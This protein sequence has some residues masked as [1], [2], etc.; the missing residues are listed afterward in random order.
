MLAF[1]CLG[2]FG[3]LQ[4]V[5]GTNPNIG[6]AELIGSA[7]FLMNAIGLAAFKSVPV[8]RNTFMFTVLLFLMVM[9]AS[10]GTHNTGILWFFV[11]PVAAFLLSDIRGGVFWMAALVASSVTVWLLAMNG[12]VTIAYDT[13]TLRQLMVSVLVVGSGIYVYQWSLEQS[14][15]ETK[16]SREELHGERAEADKVKSEF[17]TLASHQLRTPISAIAW[18]SELLL[19]GDAGKLN[20]EQQT[21]VEGIYKSNRRMAN[22]VNE[23]LIVSSLEQS[24]LP[25]ILEKT[26][27]TD[28]ASAAI[29]EQLVERHEPESRIKK[30][31]TT[32]P[33]IMCDPNVAKII[34]HHLIHN[35][36]KYTPQNGTITVRIFTDKQ[37]VGGGNVIF[38]VADTGY[39]IPKSAVKKIF[40]K[41][42]RA[43]NIL[44]KDT[45]GTGL[46]LYIVKELLNYVGGTISFRS[47]EGEG[48]TFTVQIPLQGMKEHTPKTR[49]VGPATSRSVMK[50]HAHV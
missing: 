18:T 35:A 40:T 36:L 6:Y 8:A 46:G 12:I 5:N 41:F 34:F 13:I 21:H 32:V 31:Y 49:F 29:T 22:I 30:E 1:F 28:I 39:G 42:Y 37:G 23:M 4:I 27:L 2:V 24:N 11:Y 50:G 7:I 48:T 17:V 33:A 16:A 38:E 9:M 15:D 19:N 3:T 14:K 43:K 45:D 10:G 26:Q 25:V 47:K 44:H 20:E